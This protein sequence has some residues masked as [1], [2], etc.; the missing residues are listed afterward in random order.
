MFIGVVSDTHNNLLNIDKIIEI[1]NEKKVESVI[2][3]GDI[4]KAHSL[5]KFSSLNC[6]FFA[7]YGNNDRNEFGLDK[8]AI[9]CNFIIQDPPMTL[10]RYDRKIA[11]FHEPEPINEF[12]AADNEVDIILHGHTLRYREEYINKTL[13]FNPGESAGMFKG[14]NAVGLIDLKNLIAKRIFF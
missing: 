6:D 14:K 13:L 5:E 7:V 10:D 8:I 1:F 4:T 11:V 2:H 9:D 3:T 12:L